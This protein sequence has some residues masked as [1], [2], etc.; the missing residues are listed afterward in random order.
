MKVL[1]ISAWYPHRYDAMAGLFVRKHAEAVSA[2]CEVKTLYVRADDKIKDFQLCEQITNG[3]HEVY[4]YYP[5]SPQ[6]PLYKIKKII[7]YI[8]AYKKGYDFLQKVDWSPDVVHAH[9]FTRTAFM[10]YLH[11]LWRGIPYVVTEQW[12]RYMPQNFNYKGFFHKKA[13]ELVARNA[14]C[15][16]PVSEDLKQT[17]LKNKIKGNY[18]VVYNV[19]DDFFFE[20]QHIKE[21][22]KKRM[23]HVSCF[24]E[25]HKNIK[26]ILQATHEL[27]K[28]RNDFELVIIGTGRDFDDVY[29]YAQTL[30][31]PSG[32]LVF[33]G[34]QSPQEVAE[35]YCKS[36]VFV[37]FS[38]YETAC[39][40]VQEGLA[41]GIPVIG[42]PTGIMPDFVDE[43][44]GFIVDFNDINSLT[45]KMNLLLDNL[46]KYNAEKIKDK[47]KNFTYH[48]VGQ[49]LYQIYSGIIGR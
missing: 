21:T 14:S 39:V 3:V 26:G 43:T 12:T 37:M 47:A 20:K 34:E 45:D 29:H 46:D 49:K 10:A 36:D 32:M 17:M 7:N 11:K 2:Y 38:N 18:E 5:Y 16:M 48:A 24:C 30:N 22:E 41:S 13:T 23:L 4:V 42:T 44:S 25:R 33:A 35:W 1:F 28:H 9:I 40:V 19:V 15:I 27:S 6:K 8:R 31:F